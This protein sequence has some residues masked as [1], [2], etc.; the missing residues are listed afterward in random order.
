MEEKDFYI[1]QRDRGKFYFFKFEAKEDTIDEIA[2]TYE[3][4][5]SSTWILEEQ[6]LQDLI[7]LF[8]LKIVRE[9]I[10]IVVLDTELRKEMDLEKAFRYLETSGIEVV[11]EGNKFKIDEKEYSDDELIKYADNLMD[12]SDKKVDDYLHEGYDRTQDDKAE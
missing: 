3:T 11:K 8:D 5:T 7:R 12:I 6:E 2:E 10:P 9:R 4:N 1:L